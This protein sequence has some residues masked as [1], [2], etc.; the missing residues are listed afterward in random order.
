V[1]Q[2]IA[3]S[4]TWPGIRVTPG[5]LKCSVGFNRS[6][7]C[8]PVGCRRSEKAGDHQQNR[9]GD[10]FS[11]P[12]NPLQRFAF[13]GK[14]PGGEVQRLR[15]PQGRLAAPTSDRPESNFAGCCCDRVRSQQP[16]QS[17]WIVSL[18]VAVLSTRFGSIT[19]AGT[20]TFAVLEITVP[21]VPLIKPVAL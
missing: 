21:E 17:Y 11:W 10:Q 2:K 3:L 8:S 4:F 6:L 12:G 1:L 9:C 20:S 15:Q 19:P 16:G 18:S 7:D 14:N 13:F 5:K